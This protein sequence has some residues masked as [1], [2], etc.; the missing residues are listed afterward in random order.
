MWTSTGAVG[1]VVGMSP[2]DSRLDRRRLLVLGGATLVAPSASAQPADFQGFLASLRG[3]ARV[4][5]VSDAI[6][7]GAINGLSFD[8]GPVASSR[9]Q[10][11]FAR[12]FWDY[13]NGA[14]SAARISA[15]KAAQGRAA[16]GFT[17]IKSNL[18]VDPGVVDR[19][20]VV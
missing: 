10:S 14:V 12:P 5:G 17:W 19:K 2:S 7:A 6:F 20:S 11:E 15:G 18:G 16:Q 13:V 9:Q 1:K 3:E 4:A 8:P